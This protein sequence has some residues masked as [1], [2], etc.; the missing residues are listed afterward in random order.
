MP[1]LA[2]TETIKDVI[3]D[4]LS[5]RQ[6]EELNSLL[7]E[8]KDVL[9]D[10][11]G[12]TNSYTYDKRLTSST[13]KRRKPYPTPQALRATLNGEVR[14]MLNAGITEPFDNPY[15]SPSVIVKKCCAGNR[16]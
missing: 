13:P 5:Q 7:V 4:D 15:C 6:Q 16:Y 14:N 12:R 2:Q 8:Y 11:P 10:V 1:S 3:S 9:T